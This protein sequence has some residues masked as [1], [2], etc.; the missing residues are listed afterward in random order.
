[1][2]S[3]ASSTRDGELFW[4][5]PHLRL[6]PLTRLS[7]AGALQNCTPGVALFDSG[8]RCAAVNSVLVAM[9][10]LSADACLGK[11]LPEIFGGHSAS[12]EQPFQLARD[13]RR[14]VCNVR[15]LAPLAGNAALRQWIVDLFPLAD[16]PETFGWIGMAL[17]EAPAERGSQRGLLLPASDGASSPSPVAPQGHS[18]SP[19]SVWTQRACAVLL[20]RTFRLLDLSMSL[21]RQVSATRVA[22]SLLRGTAWPVL[23]DHAQ[24]SPTAPTLIQ[25]A[26][27]NLP[28]PDHPASQPPHPAHSLSSRE[29]E[30]LCFLADGKTNKEIAALLV[31]SARTVE[32]YRARLMK[33]LDLHTLADIIRYA[34]RHH[35]V[36][37]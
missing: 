2:P 6:R 18:L 32:V 7:L 21:R 37:V 22:A 26:C 5:S 25:P 28:N 8:V 30:V 29:M 34:I 19:Q 3:T 27:D 15:V 35:L 13:T 10:G 1:M 23:E 9:T 36:E 16:L 4:A 14:S 24:P 11:T 33:K 12:L 20:Q 17:C 31:L